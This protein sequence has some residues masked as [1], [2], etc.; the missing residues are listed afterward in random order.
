M[1]LSTSQIIV[2]IPKGCCFEQKRPGN[3][4]KHEFHT[5]HGYANKHPLY[6]KWL[7]IKARCYNTK[8]AA[9]PWYGAKGIQMATEW[10]DNFVSFFNWAINNGWKKGLT[11]DRIDPLLNYCAE[12]CQFITLSDNSKRRNKNTQQAQD[13]PELR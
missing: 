13:G 12:N 8:H 3:K 4:L 5:V 2:Q 7:A 10:K 9:Y 1:I 6:T 11:I